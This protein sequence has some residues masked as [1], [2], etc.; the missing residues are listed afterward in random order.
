MLENFANLVSCTAGPPD[1]RF[2][3]EHFGPVTSS[4]HRIFAN[5]FAAEEPM[6]QPPV[7]F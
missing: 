3:P 6:S 1:M 5:A 4:S 2:F 7:S